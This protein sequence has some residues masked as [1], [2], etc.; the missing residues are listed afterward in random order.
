MANFNHTIRQTDFFDDV[1]H[2]GIATKGL[3]IKGVADDV[4]EQ[5][6]FCDR[7]I[8]I[9]FVL[10]KGFDQVGNIRLGQDFE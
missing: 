8:V 6:I 5:K 10:I 9:V 1:H 7:R 4:A 2:M 3:D